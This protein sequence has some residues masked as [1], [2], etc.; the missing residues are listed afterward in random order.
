MAGLFQC[1]FWWA[2]ELEYIDDK[3]I[4]ADSLIKTSYKQLADRLSKTYDV[5]IYP[6]DWRK[7][8][9]ECA[10]EFNEKM[11]DLLKKNMPIKIIGHSMGGLLVRDFIINY[12]DTWQKLNLSNG[13]RLLFLG[14]PL[15]GSF[16]IP[17]VLFGNDAI[18]NSLNM[19]DRKHTKKELIAMFATF[20][21]ILSLLPLTTEANNDF[22][23]IDTWKKM[24][25]TMG[26]VNWPI[27]S[28]ADL[29]VFKNYR[30]NIIAKR[31]DID[32]SKMM[33]IAGK[34]KSTPCGYYN[35]TIPPRTEL[36][37]EY[38]AEGDQSVTWELGIPKQMINKNDASKS[39]VYYV[40]VSHG[41]L[42]NEPDIFSGIEELLAK[43]NTNILSKNKP[44][45]RGEEQVFRMPELFNFD[46]SERGIHNAVF[47]ITEKNEP[48]VNQIPISI[49]V[50]NGDLSYAS[51]PLLAGHFNNDGILYAEKSIDRNVN[52]SLHDRHYLGL[53]PGA[54]GTNTIIATDMAEQNFR[55]AIIAGLGEPGKLTSY[56][57]TKTVEQAVC[58]YLLNMNSKPD[59]KQDIGISALIIGCGYGGLTI[60]NSLKSIIEGTNNANK[61]VIE[62]RKKDIKTVQH[63]EFIEVYEDKAL[64]CLYALSKIEN[65][66]NRIYNITL[67]NKKIKELF[68]LKKRLP[69][70]TSDEWWNRLTVKL[71]KIQENDEV[72]QSLVFNASTSDAREEEKELFSSLSLVNLFIKEI[73]AKNRWTAT[74]AKTLFELMIPNEFKENLKKKGNICWVLDKDTAAYPW[75]L[76]KE[77]INETK[78]LCIGAGM[79][80]QLSTTDYSQNINRVATEMALV[81]ADPML[82]GF[83]TQLKGAEAEGLLVKDLFT[84]NGYQNISLINKTASEIVLNLFSND[85]KIIHL[86]GHGIYNPKAKQ[87]SGMVIG[88]DMYLTTAD[89][90]QM[91][92]VPELVFVNC[93]HL[94]AVDGNDEKF[95]R[96]RYKL[97]ANIGTELI[98]MGVKAVI[99]AGWA[100]DDT[101]AT[102]FANVFYT[103]IFD[104]YNFGDAVTA[105]RSS[106]YEKYHHK[107]NTWGA[108]QCYGDPFYKL[109]NRSVSTKNDVIK[110][111]I[112]EEVEI[113]LNNLRN[114][115]DTKNI[116]SQK[117]IERLKLI[118]DAM[119]EAK[120]GCCKIL[121]EQALIY[122]ELGEYNL[123]IQKF[124]ELKL[125]E[126]AGFSVATLEK[127]CNAQGKRCVVDFK[128][129]GSKN[130]LANVMDDIIGELTLLLKINT[131]SERTTLMGSAYKRKAM[132]TTNP[133]AKLTAYKNAALNYKKAFDIKDGTYAF[134]KWII[135]QTVIDIINNDPAEKGMFG[136]KTIAETISMVELRRSKL[137][138]NFNNMDYWQLIEDVSY[139]FSLLMLDDKKSKKEEVWQKIEEKFKRIWRNSGSKGKKMAEIENFEI[140]ADALSLSTVKRATYLKER[141]DDLKANLE[142]DLMDD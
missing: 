30:D 50:S 125:E 133:K 91:S 94:G 15:G 86:A 134:N 114:D 101:A 58:K 42:A 139:D 27:P 66:E 60:E 87:K 76:L 16:R 128:S 43:G 81:V 13:F 48:T 92:T 55:G 25:E 72:T 44:V 110:Y 84:S 3:T 28:A 38:T 17:T 47:G 4:T 90:K 74:T 2:T 57:L 53:Y 105:A 36:V 8:L 126:Y 123:A 31:D 23:N 9:N 46:F 22:A 14:S 136:K 95:F 88:K 104:G 37:F 115:L 24:A 141:I 102:E 93:C 131:T 116:N 85:Y 11:I 29:E 64:S 52:G 137:C 69:L 79:I 98:E 107:N 132:V 5:V 108:Y 6:F 111:I 97:A 19:L 117:T 129:K 49:S 112:D 20:P 83:V 65:K 113:D 118:N 61:K 33:Y 82:D 1:R 70:S 21:G 142:K 99:A 12:D 109:I 138:S 35:D 80:R 122:Y 67:A 124:E 41:A 18:I 127:Y 45:A 96:D 56:L 68:G 121:E 71:K 106:I 100:V 75:E 78:P 135:F 62:C 7:Q 59:D 103:K 63:I 89:I 130:S 51:Y 140:L 120:I 39:S 26:D 119:N 54:I 10:K 34:D 77:N 40:D 73:S 32:Y